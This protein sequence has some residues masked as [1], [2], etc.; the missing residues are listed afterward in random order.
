MFKDFDWS[1]MGQ[2]PESMLKMK[3]QLEKMQNELKNKKGSQ[4]KEE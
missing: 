1:K 4:T 2:D 3:E